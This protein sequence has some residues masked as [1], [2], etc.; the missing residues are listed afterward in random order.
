MTVTL[1]E[2]GWWHNARKV[3]SPHFD[4]R[5]DAH[6]ISLL[7][8]H[9]I[10]L[11]PGQFGSGDVE[12]FF[13]G[14]I[15]SSA[16]PYFE[17]IAHLRVSAHFFIRRDGE[18]VQFVATGARAWHAGVSSFQGRER[19]NDYS[20]GIELEGSDDTPFNSAQYHQLVQLSTD[21]LRAFPRI[22]LERI[23]GHQHIAPERKTDP[24]PFFDWDHYR[25]ALCA[26]NN[27]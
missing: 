10:S 20:L 5:P 22:T 2:N 17:S 16:H 21:I 3:P 14:H 6:D 11:P 13:T 27:R 8:L 23:V 15:N 24:G 4:A 9:N 19:C 12:A 18:V 7:V 1:W 25:R 26:S